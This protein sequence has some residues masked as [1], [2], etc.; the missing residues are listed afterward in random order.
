MKAK[1]KREECPEC[2]DAGLSWPTVL[3]L[4]VLCGT[5]LGALY[6]VLTFLIRVL[7]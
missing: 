4:A 5:G 3:L 2:G 6:M 1:K 7:P